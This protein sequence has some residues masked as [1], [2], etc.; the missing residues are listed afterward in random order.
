MSGA[1]PSRLRVQGRA[2]KAGSTAWHVRLAQRVVLDRLQALVTGRLEIELPDG[3]QITVGQGGAPEARLVVH[4]PRFFWRLLVGSDV[5]AGE[6]FMAREWDTP[7]LAALVQ[8]FVVNAPVL[9]A[10]SAWSWLS[11]LWGRLHHTRRRNTR[12][13][14]RRN[15]A[16]HYDLSNDFY[17][18]FLDPGMTYSAAQFEYPGQGLEAAQQVKL[19]TIAAKARVHPGL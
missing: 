8:L 6:A 15:I 18:L 16:A 3:R 12:R 4:H 9:D 19:Q 1:A 11:G 14:S 5:G 10:P 7:D 2:S 13:G 17:G